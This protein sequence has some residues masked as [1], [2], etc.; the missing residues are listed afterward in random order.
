M[1]HDKNVA[2][3]LEFPRGKGGRQK[4]GQ[5][6]A[7][8]ESIHSSHPICFRACSDDF[9]RNCAVCT[10]GTSRLPAVRRTR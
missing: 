3:K 9:P 5:L 7:P 6:I 1:T 4:E 8:T 2:S 10:A